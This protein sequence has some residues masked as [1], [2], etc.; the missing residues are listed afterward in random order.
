MLAIG[1]SREPSEE[2]EGGG[3]GPLEVI[4]EDDEG[5]GLLGKDVDEVEE[6]VVEAVEVFLGGEGRHRWGRADEFGEG[7]EDVDHDLGVGAE[8]GE[9]L[10]APALALGFVFGEELVD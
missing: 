7:G 10:L 6:G 5:V 8:G 3:V 9:E 1:V 2:L 4:E